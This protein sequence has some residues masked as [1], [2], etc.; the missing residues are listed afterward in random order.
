M[1]EPLRQTQGVFNSTQSRR[2]KQYT[3]G[4][5]L[6]QLADGLEKGTIGY[7]R[8]NGLVHLK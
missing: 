1:R 3:Y 7:Q 8:D 6:Q 2:V 5:I 4:Q